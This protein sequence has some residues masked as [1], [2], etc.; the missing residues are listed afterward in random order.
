MKLFA[1]L[2]W[3]IILVG[4]EYGNDTWQLLHVGFICQHKKIATL[5]FILCSW[6]IAVIG[7]F[8]VWVLLD[9]FV[10]GVSDKLSRLD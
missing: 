3:L 1:T 8:F 2:F 4:Q 9:L 6:H 5:L 7:G 10:C